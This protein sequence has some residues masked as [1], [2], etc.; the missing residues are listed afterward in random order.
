MPKKR[1]KK[2]KP[3]NDYY[4]VERTRPRSQRRGEEERNAVLMSKRKENKEKKS[5]V[6][7]RAGDGL[8][9]VRKREQVKTQKAIQTIMISGAKRKDG[10]CESK[11]LPF[12]NNAIFHCRF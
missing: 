2:N 1:P 6:K 11:R 7:S 8:M 5:R 3:Q 4:K 12:S 10:V 9:G